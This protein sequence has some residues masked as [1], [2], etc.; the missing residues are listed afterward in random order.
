[1]S[2]NKRDSLENIRFTLINARCDGSAMKILKK[3]RKKM[4]KKGRS[5]DG[6]LA[7]IQSTV[8]REQ[9]HIGRNTVNVM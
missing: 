4:K 7:C 9:T 3:N 2:S 6:A 1:M 8:P 5:Q